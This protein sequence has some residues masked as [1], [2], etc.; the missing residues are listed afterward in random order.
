[1][2]VNIQV[3]KEKKE[4]LMK[5]ADTLLLYKEGVYA[6][7]YN[8]IKFNTETIKRS[9][10]RSNECEFLTSA[11]IT[12]YTGTGKYLGTTIDDGTV[13]RLLIKNDLSLMRENWR[14]LKAQLLAFGFTINRTPIKNLKLKNEQH[15]EKK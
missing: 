14:N 12:G 6:F 11:D 3:T 2:K 15:P 10:G 5:H 8:N 9:F 7:K 13:Y 4:E 1:M